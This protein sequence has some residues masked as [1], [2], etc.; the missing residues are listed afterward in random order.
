MITAKLKDLLIEQ[1]G[2]EL[3]AHQNYMAIAL[4]F[5]RQSLDKWGKLFRAQALEEAQHATK[6]MDFLTDCE[7]DFDLPALKGASTKYKSAQSAVETA[8]KSEKFNTKQFEA[9]AAAAVKA[10]DQTVFQFT[11]WFLEEQVE[12]EAK[13]QKLLDLVKSGINL[14]QAEALLEA[15]E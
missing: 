10:S 2:V 1:I 8:L 5:E 15:F 9:I 14:F 11:Q 4:Y 3:G 7:A 6:I 12:E 13:M